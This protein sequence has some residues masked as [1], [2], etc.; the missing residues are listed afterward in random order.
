MAEIKFK[1]KLKVYKQLIDD[2]RSNYYDA[3]GIMGDNN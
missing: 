3:L 1:T 2:H